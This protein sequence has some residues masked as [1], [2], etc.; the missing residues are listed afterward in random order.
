MDPTACLDII[1]ELTEKIIVASD[2]DDDYGYVAA[3][4]DHAYELAD[5]VQALDEWIM[6]GGLL[7]D[8]WADPPPKEGD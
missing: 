2:G 6:K 5:H 7:P 1:R 3:A 8:T 4:L